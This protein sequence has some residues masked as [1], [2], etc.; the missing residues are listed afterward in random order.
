MLRNFG[1]PARFV[2]LTLVVAS[3]SEYSNEQLGDALFP[4]TIVCVAVIGCPQL[5]PTYAAFDT[6]F[7][8]VLNLKLTVPDGVSCKPPIDAV[9]LPLF[10]NSE[11]EMLNAVAML[12]PP[13]L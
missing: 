12:P 3:N 11:L 8:T 5:I 4:D 7:A 13:P 6:L 2:P 10:T 9:P 1:S